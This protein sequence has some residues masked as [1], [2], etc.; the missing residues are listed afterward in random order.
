M[1]TALGLVRQY[2][3]LDIGVTDASMPQS[4]GGMARRAF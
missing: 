2:K 4:P 1:A 3:D